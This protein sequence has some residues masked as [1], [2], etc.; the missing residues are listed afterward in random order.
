MVNSQELLVNSQE[1][2]V[3][4]QELSVIVQELLITTQELRIHLGLG[5]AVEDFHDVASPKIQLQV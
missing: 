3:I 5:E 4:I 2:L 1:L